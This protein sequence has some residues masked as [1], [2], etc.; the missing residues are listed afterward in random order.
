MSDLIDRT[1]EREEYLTNMVI[2]NRTRYVG[3][4]RLTCVDCGDSIP[5][6]RREALSGIKQCIY[7]ASEGVI[8]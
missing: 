2:A 8:N 6:G 5:Q 1:V 7:C 4:S 3:E